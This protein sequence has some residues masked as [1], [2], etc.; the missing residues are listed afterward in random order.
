MVSFRR[1]TQS[2]YD[3]AYNSKSIISTNN[4]PKEVYLWVDDDGNALYYSDAEVIFMNEDSSH[5]FG[6]LW[7][8]SDIDVS[9]F[10][11]SKVTN[12]SY[13]FYEVGGRDEDIITKLDLSNFDTHNVTNMSHMF[14]YAYIQEL[15]ISSF[16][17]SN[18]ID[19][20]YMFASTWY[21]PEID[22]SNFDTSNVTTMSYMFAD[23]NEITELDLSNFD[24]SNVT[25]MS[26][27]FYG[28]FDFGN[29]LTVLDLSTFDTSNVTNMEY[30]FEH[31]MDLRTIYVT[32]LWNTDS[33]T[34]AGLIFDKANSLIG[35]KGTAV[36]TYAG[37]VYYDEI[38]QNY[39]YDSVIFARV[40]GG[41]SNPGY[42]TYKG[43]VGDFS[44]LNIG[45]ITYN[46]NSH[47]PGNLRDKI[48]NSETPVVNLRKATEEEY[49]TVKD[50]L[51]DADIYSTSNSPYPTY[52]WID[53]DTALYY[54]EASVIYANS[55]LNGA[56]YSTHLVNVD[57][58]GLNT[59]LLTDTRSILSH[60][61]DLEQV[62]LSGWDTSRVFDTNGM[63]K[64]SPLLTTIYVSDSWD[65]SNASDSREM[66]NGT[67]SIVGQEGTTYDASHIDKEYA[68]ID[69]GETNPGYLTYKAYTPTPIPGDVYTVTLPDRTDIVAAGST[70]VIPN[71]NYDKADE[72]FATVTFK[73]QDG[74]TSDLVKTISTKYINNGFTIGSTHYDDEDTIIVNENITL[75]PEYVEVETASIEFPEDPT[76]TGYKFDGWYT[77]SENGTKV[78]SYSAHEDATLYAHWSLDLPNPG[79]EYTLPENIYTTIEELATVTFVYGNGS[80]NTTSKVTSVSLGNG[81]LVDGVHYDA[82]E[83][84]VY[85][86]GMTI[87]KDCLPAVITPAKFP[88][89]P[90]KTGYEFKGWFDTAAQAGGNEYTEYAET[91]DI[92]LYARW[93]GESAPAECTAFETY[94]TGVNNTPKADAVIATTTFVYH[95]GQPN[96]TTK[97]TASFTPNGWENNGVHYG[98]NQVINRCSTEPVNPYYDKVIK[99]GTFP[100]NP[101]KNGYEFI[102]WFTEEEGGEQVTVLRDEE[103]LVLHAHWTS[104]YSIVSTG[105]TRFEG[106][107]HLKY[108]TR[109]YLDYLL[110]RY[111]KTEADIT[112]DAPSWFQIYNIA[113][114]G[115]PTY[116]WYDS[117]EG[118]TYY[119]SDA[120]VI[121]LVE[122]G[123]EGNFANTNFYYIDMSKLNTSK[124]TDMSGMF[125]HSDH[126]SNIRFGNIN[127]SNVTDMSSMFEQTKLESADF[128][129]FDTSKVTNMSNMFGNISEYS[130]M[131]TFDLSSFDTSN[132]TNMEGMFFDW[133][134]RDI[135]ELDLSSF[136]TSSVTNAASMFAMAEDNESILETI[137][138]SKKWDL[139]D[140]TDSDYMFS[141]LTTI[142]GQ[143]G[144]TYDGDKIDKEYAIIDDAPEHPG[145]LSYKIDFSEI[146]QKPTKPLLCKRATELHTGYCGDDNV[147]GWCN[148]VGLLDQTIYFGNISTSDVLQPGDALD[149]DVNGDGIYGGSY[150]ERFYYVSD[151]YDTETK[152][153]NS[154]YAALIW[155]TDY[156]YSG[157]TRMTS[158]NIWE[159]FNAGTET[160]Y[161]GPT[162]VVEYYDFVLPATSSWTNVTL[163]KD[164]RYILPAL[165]ELDSPT[166]FWYR[167]L[168][169]R[170]LNLKE[171]ES[172]CGIEVTSKQDYMLPASCSFL[173]E[174]ALVHEE[175][176]SGPYW[177]ETPMD[178]E[179]PLVIH[180]G[181]LK[182]DDGSWNSRPVIDVPKSQIEGVK[183][184]NTI[185][186][187]DGTSDEVDTG[188]TYA[189]KTNKSTK[190]NTAVSTVTFDHNDGTGKT[191][192]AE[193]SKSYIAS[194][195]I[196][197][198]THY[199]DATI[200]TVTSDITVEYDY[201]ETTV[202]VEFPSDPER[203]GYTF[204]GWYNDKTGGSVVTSYD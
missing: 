48:N 162:G 8:L 151:Y 166:N 201:I 117:Q 179:T 199:D 170:L 127:T 134:V 171:L 176:Y 196:I 204:N 46:T 96:T 74:V 125:E 130:Y 84:I 65:I 164:H 33:V 126:L 90:T 21:T 23:A 27:M 121:F 150:G 98:N 100:A 72:V 181:Y 15:D 202:G 195:W 184:T 104:N 186:Y 156:T 169:G 1:A 138:V 187:P 22:V 114:E 147:F 123:N 76:V 137:Y 115:M 97:T 57:L 40:D 59:S 142:V 80:A 198:G 66:F 63:F 165:E 128:S 24:T 58:S 155:S 94:T 185:T 192:I 41:P 18:V 50:S 11:T 92:T 62:D 144:T 79:E 13:M 154:S 52:G 161:D 173:L 131:E 26:A 10:N 163:Y 112:P 116:I 110:N 43:N 39:E 197:D 2:E 36:S 88:A 148:S 178:E 108:G 109:T 32:D 85:L 188:S 95:N 152:S 77:D 105:F 106:A 177:I 158:Y 78:T 71:N 111:E 167:E 89:N 31:C 30:M 47:I 133:Q 189:L 35:Q 82:G 159:E 75:I 5:I 118:I 20:S 157:D 51:T 68:I 160:R 55:S 191:T 4:S 141:G 140:A 124:M 44:L 42:L 3:D 19:M 182:Q 190:D 12:M 168:A 145:Y 119:Y 83:T 183:L 146:P 60:N 153:F 45:F 38:Y 61:P 149:C 132:V 49:N 9:E 139:S 193:V 29:K 120:D 122:N 69:G 180:S 175:W 135:T 14:E 56:F 136:D 143:N 107:H 172:A 7:K 91:E 53:G 16:D 54:S 87:E 129:N 113:D 34:E 93:G 70:Y 203:L 37:G 101:T 64:N 17:T 103:D 73:Y 67:T 25:D 81:W 174:D 102:G 28:D 86:E 200:I 6:G 194:G 99:N